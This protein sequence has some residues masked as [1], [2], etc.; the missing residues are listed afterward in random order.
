MRKLFNFIFIALCSLLVVLGCTSSKQNV[1][2]G[3]VYDESTMKSL[4]PPPKNIPCYLRIFINI[5]DDKAK[6]E[7]LMGRILAWSPKISIS[8]G[9]LELYVEE[10]AA[11]CLETRML[12]ILRMIIS[13]TVP[14]QFALDINS[15][16]YKKYNITEEELEGLR[17]IR[18]IDS[19]ASFTEKEKAALKYAHALSKTPIILT[20]KHLDDLRRLF[21]EEEIVAIAALTAK[22]NYWARLFEALRI[23]PAGYTDDPI[24]HLEDYNILVK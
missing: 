6:K 17:G 13:Y 21:S 4:V 1:P 7:M 12:T 3:G 23:K 11:L 8:S 9:L 19:I 16:N 18:D 24:L 20:Q 14:S 5:A 15:C 10:G 22:V 2:V